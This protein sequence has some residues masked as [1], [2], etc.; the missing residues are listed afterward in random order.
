MKQG[1]QV[2]IVDQDDIQA[3]AIARTLKAANLLAGWRRVTSAEELVQALL[4]KADLLVADDSHAQ[5]G[6]RQTLAIL[7]AN[8]LEIPLIVVTSQGDSADAVVCMKAGAADYL[9]RVHLFRLPEA[10]HDALATGGPAGREHRFEKALKLI[11]SAME[12]AP[13]PLI[14]TNRQGHIVWGNEAAVT[15]LKY[16]LPDLTAS[17]ISRLDPSFTGQNWTQLRDQL[18]NGP[19]SYTTRLTDKTGHPVAAD[20]H[21][22]VVRQDEHDFYLFY[23]QPAMPSTTGPEHTGDPS[24]HPQF[25]RL[26]KLA[27]FGRLAG[28]VVHDFNNLLTAINGYSELIATHLKPDHPLQSYVEQIL[29]T[30]DH[31]AILAKQL[32]G[33]SRRLPQQL[34]VIDLNA[35]LRDMTAMLKRLLRENI[36]L[37][38]TLQANIG[39][40]KADAAQVEQIIVNLV[41]NARD[42]MP[43]GGTLKIETSADQ[44]EK[45]LPLDHTELPAG[46]YLVLSIQDSGHGM[47]EQVRSKLFTPFFTTKASGTGLGLYTV[48]RYAV[49]NQGGIVCQSEPGK[50]TMFQLYLPATGEPLPEKEKRNIPARTKSGSETILLVEDDEAIRHATQRLLQ[51]QGYQV[52]DFRDGDEALLLFENFPHP[53][54]LIITDVMLPRMNGLELSAKMRAKQPQLKVLYISGYG[55]A[56]GLP[57]FPAESGNGSDFIEKPFTVEALEKKIRKLLEK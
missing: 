18:A 3:A 54:H 2:I 10:V 35:L 19:V 14:W 6:A 17:H 46:R 5:F 32:L 55:N 1:L 28:G 27:A 9:S 40:I 29:K 30:S 21:G 11:K 7:K 57:K 31:G 47:D 20:I 42:A 8:H 53:I 45:P 56:S 39:P 38:T 12:Q 24:A 22:R 51:M 26:E 13:V 43:Q 15:L 16:D 36:E 34:T 50:G 33:F 37:R 23:I 41:L 49:I 52:L 25:E 44:F 48:L 4:Q